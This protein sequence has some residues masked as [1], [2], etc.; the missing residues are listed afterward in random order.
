MKLP[1]LSISETNHFSE[2]KGIQN[3][4]PVI[5]K[6]KSTKKKEKFSLADD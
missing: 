6:L 5:I 1:K 3:S 4:R 2:S